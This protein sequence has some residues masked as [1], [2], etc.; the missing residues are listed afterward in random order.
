MTTRRGGRVALR[1]LDVVVPVAV[2][3]ALL[4][5][6]WLN[7]GYA[8][9]VAGALGFVVATQIVPGAVLWR[10]LR[11][12]QGAW[13][14]DLA[15]GG[16]LALVVSGLLGALGGY[17][18]APWLPLLLIAVVLLLLLVPPV[19][20]AWRA[21]P[22]TA[23]PP[24]GW[25]AAVAATGVTVLATYADYALD[26]PVVWGGW[27]RHFIDGPYHLA[28]AG[29]VLHHGPEQF[30]WV[31]GTPMRYP[32]LM[33]G[34]DAS[35]AH[36]PGLPL[37]VVVFRA[38]P[39]ILL[40]LLP[41]V[42]AAT[43]WRL[44]GRAWAGPVGALLVLATGS[45]GIGTELATTPIVLNSPPQQLGL[46]VLP[47]AV[48]LLALRWRGSSRTWSWIALVVL[49]VGLFLAKGGP[50]PVLVAGMG[51]AAAVWVVLSR[52]RAQRV[53]LLDLALAV[54][55]FAVGFRV[56]LGGSA[57]DLAL[58]PLAGMVRILTGDR[59]TVVTASTLA[60]A[61]LAF[62]FSR[63]AGTTAGLLLLERE[64]RTDLVRWV[65]LGA[66]LAGIGAALLLYQTGMS[67]QYFLVAGV[68]VGSLG[69]AWGIAQTWDR[70][71]GPR[72]VAVG[73]LAGVIAW[74]VQ[75]G[76]A[77][78]MTD[79]PD[80]DGH[81][82]RWALSMGLVLLVALLVLV[83]SLVR[84]GRPW[85]G[86]VLRGLAIA[87]TFAAVASI[88]PRVVAPE[89]LVVAPAAPG[90]SSAW[91][92]ANVAAATFLQG[93]SQPSDVV[94]TNRHC[95][96]LPLPDCDRRAFVISAYTQRR[97]LVEGWAYTPEAIVAAAAATP[98]TSPFAGPF[99][100]PAR[101]DL[102]DRFLA[103]PTSTDA[104]RLWDE[105]VRWA[106]VDRVAGRTGDLSPYAVEVFANEEATVYRLLDPAR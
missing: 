93:A 106:Y 44:S 53:V 84:P 92:Q 76:I 56:L 33:Y 37:D 51:L 10:L 3:G 91:S 32:W 9:D 39:V 30:S 8:G 102:N 34:W 88:V 13:V 79:V 90:S 81:A 98:P 95:N 97:V 83:V 55:V 67:Q 4:R 65:V 57:S 101:L 18:R 75:Y 61:T 105:G 5:I 69:A 38:T 87:V 31:A 46:V 80:Y 59:A 19:R 54:A 85:A 45:L 50:F 41:F 15:L 66:P 27:M 77:Q 74:A 16:G 96:S 73:A 2:L 42:M 64:R 20:R 40:T 23:L 1:V 72:L 99:W 89:R 26:N 7:G 17:L 48:A 52:A 43:A 82:Q 86:D 29:E 71:G 62:A 11:R 78:L 63:L 14:E 28:L 103:A 21:T 36:L 22:T 35:F 70:S 58:D 24:P 49:L 60:A 12:D 25:V 47:C 68:V 100:D 104:R 94:M 6:T